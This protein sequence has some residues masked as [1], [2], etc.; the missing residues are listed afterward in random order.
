VGERL[1]EVGMKLEYLLIHDCMRLLR[2]EYET[3]ND[4]RNIFDY[5]NIYFLVDCVKIQKDL[6]AEI[7]EEC[8]LAKDSDR[9][10]AHQAIYTVTNITKVVKSFG[11]AQDRWQIICKRD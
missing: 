5:S 7:F 11:C 3:R 9:M 2:F 4:A 8:I 6:L 1:E 10:I